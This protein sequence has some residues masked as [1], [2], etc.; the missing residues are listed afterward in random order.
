VTKSN[1]ERAAPDPLAVAPG[2]RYTSN[3]AVLRIE[4]ELTADGA[5]IKNRAEP[6]AASNA[7]VDE[8][9]AEIEEEAASENPDRQR[10]AALNRQLKA[11]QTDE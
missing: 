1:E 10:I 8:L 2:P 7:T 6:L 4:E 9:R 11:L 3:P 5:T